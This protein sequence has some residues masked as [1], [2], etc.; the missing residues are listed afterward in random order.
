[1]PLDLQNP[2]Q[3]S[4][5]LGLHLAWGNLLLLL[6]LQFLSSL[7]AL[8]WPLTPWARRGMTEEGHSPRGDVRGAWQAVPPNPSETTTLRSSPLLGGGRQRTVHLIWLVGVVVKG[9][10][11]IPKANI[12]TFVTTG[13]GRT[14]EF[15]FRSDWHIARTNQRQLCHPGHS[16]HH[17]RTRVSSTH[18]QSPPLS[19]ISAAGEAGA[20]SCS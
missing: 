20:P 16:E 3:A 10:E 17:R 13:T 4:P 12:L 6:L 15:V 19:R 1:M 8:P 5:K 18:L 7:P 9:V 2:G 14:V 11:I